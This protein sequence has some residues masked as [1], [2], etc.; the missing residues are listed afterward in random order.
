MATSLKGAIFAVHFA[1]AKSLAQGAIDV[2]AV[3]ISIEVFAKAT[4]ESVPR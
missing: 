1:V 3:G 2:L 4:V